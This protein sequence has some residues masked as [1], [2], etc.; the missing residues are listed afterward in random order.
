MLIIGIAWIIGV[1]L[2][3][4]FWEIFISFWQI[5]AR[6]KEGKLI[7]MWTVVFPFDKVHAMTSKPWKSIRRKNEL[8]GSTVCV[9]VRLCES[10]SQNSV[11]IHIF[12]HQLTLGY[13]F[14]TFYI[15]YLNDKTLIQMGVDIR[16]FANI[17]YMYH[18]I[19]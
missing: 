5:R 19:N 9:W 3:W 16:R 17:S 2:W 6:G 11:K 8:G 18:C 15:L 10:V 13:N 7:Q 1:P 14:Q 4:I 12:T